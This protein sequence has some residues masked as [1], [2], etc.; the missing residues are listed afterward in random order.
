V[1]AAACGRDLGDDRLYPSAVDVDHADRRA[2]TRKAHSPRATHARSASRH[3]ADLV[4][5]T[6]A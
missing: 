3:D 4:L 2:F 5:Q 6:H 1:C